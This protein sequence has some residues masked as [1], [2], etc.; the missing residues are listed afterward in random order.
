MNRLRQLAT[1]LLATAFAVVQLLATA[2]LL[3][4][5][6]NLLGSLTLQ[7]P[8]HPALHTPEGTSTGSTG[9]CPVCM[10]SGLSA[11]LS[12]GLSVF[13]PITRVAAPPLPAYSAIRALPGE[14]LRSR[15]PPAL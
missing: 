11:V 6:C 2:P 14:D 9:E 4:P 12:P 8:A 7:G 10:V 1:L 13:A 5:H 3:H 15:A